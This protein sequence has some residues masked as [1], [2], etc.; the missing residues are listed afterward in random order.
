MSGFEFRASSFTFLLLAAFFLPARFL[1][2]QSDTV[3]SPSTPVV[4]VS[5]GHIE[6]HLALKFSSD[7]A[8]SPDASMLAVVSGDKILI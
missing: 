3:V 6:G 1:R 8:F 5:H 2:A 4:W 7:G